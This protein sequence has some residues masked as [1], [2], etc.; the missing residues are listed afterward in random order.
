V[1]VRGWNPTLLLLLVLPPYNFGVRTETIGPDLPRTR[2]GVGDCAR[3]TKNRTQ[4]EIKTPDE[5][6]GPDN[7]TLTRSFFGL[8]PLLA[9]ILL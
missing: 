4:P 5:S 9:A 7:R 6:H 8:R 2:A 3:R 1:K